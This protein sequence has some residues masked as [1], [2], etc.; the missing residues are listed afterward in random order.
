MYESMFVSIYFQ[1]KMF[2]CFYF[3]KIYFKVKLISNFF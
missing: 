2:P 1:I 3:V